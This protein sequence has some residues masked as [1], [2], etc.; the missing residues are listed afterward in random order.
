M[1]RIRIAVFGL[2]AL[3]AFGL[4]AA[5]ATAQYWWWPPNMAVAPQFPTTEDEVTVTMGGEWPDS[6]IPNDSAIAGPVD[7]EICFDVIWDYPPGTICLMVITPWARSE[8]IGPL[9][10]GTYSVYATLFD[11]FSGLPMTE[12]TFVGSFT[13]EDVWLLGDANCDGSVDYGDIDP[14]VLALSGQE[15]FADQYPGC[16][17]LNSDCNYDGTVDYDDIDAFVDCL[18][19]ASPY[20]ADD[21]YDGC[22]PGRGG[23]RDPCGEDE[24]E[25]SVED[26]TLHAVHRNALYNCCL[27]EIVISL[28]MEDDVLRFDEVEILTMPCWCE[29]CFDAGATVV[30]LAPG[31]YTVEF[32]WFDYD[33]WQ[34]QCL[35]Q[36]V[37]IP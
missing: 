2:A 28:T 4:G 1:G 9:P 29:C 32:C 12:P 25:L 37:V 3:A 26:G 10:A 17:W 20:L 22:L 13:V 33:T 19:S 30:D 16:P 5:E 35:E 14:F 31:T 11:G 15:G 24:L 36:A 21:W 34:E 23:A 8:T 27:D 7:D 18:G 6:C